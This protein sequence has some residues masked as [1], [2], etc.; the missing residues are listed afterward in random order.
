MM[1]D[2]VAGERDVQDFVGSSTGRTCRL[3][4]D[5]VEGAPDRGRQF[6]VSAGMHHDI[7]D[8]AHQ[9]LAEPDLRV[10][11]PRRCH[12]LA[13][14]QIAEMGRDRGRAD[15]DRE[16]QRSLVKSR[17]ET[18]ESAV[19]ANRG[20]DLPAPAPQARL[21]RSENRHAGAK[22]LD[23]ALRQ[24]SR[25]PA[26]VARGIMHVRLGDLHEMQAHQRI[27]V[28]RVRLCPLPHHLP[29]HLRLRRDVD[30]E[31]AFDLRLTSET[32]SVRQ[33]SQPAVSL[34]DRVGRADVLV[35]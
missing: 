12:D 22:V 2:G 17:P 25:E 23:A 18:D 14:R 34:L 3:C 33:A 15:V 1:H 5:L 30:D 4:D 27:H 20:G 35:A 9:I 28:D 11:H 24:R 8:P 13:A 29:M 7:R 10:H 31:I 6:R 32:A 19:A 16:A 26:E 21:Q